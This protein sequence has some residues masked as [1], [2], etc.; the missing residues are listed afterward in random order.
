MVLVKTT[1][2]FLSNWIVERADGHGGPLAAAM[3]QIADWLKELGMPEYTQRSRS[4]TLKVAVSKFHIS[5]GL[6]HG[7]DPDHSPIVTWDAMKATTLRTDPMTMW[8]GIILGAMAFAGT[9]FSGS[10]ADYIGLLGCFPPTDPN[11]IGPSSP[12]HSDSAQASRQRLK[13]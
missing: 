6:R 13:L 1:G 10:N 3:E 5:V 4:R 12:D 11:D 9:A 7:C 8:L 2:S